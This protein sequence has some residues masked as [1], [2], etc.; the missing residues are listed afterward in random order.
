MRRIILV[1]A[2]AVAALPFLL[3]GSSAVAGAGNGVLAVDP[4]PHQRGVAHH[5]LYLKVFGQD[6]KGRPI[7]T[8]TT[9][10]G[11]TP[12]HV[13]TA[14]GFSSL[15]ATGSGQV[16]GIVDAYDAP[17]I[18]SDLQTFITTFGL[19]SMY[20]LP[21]TSA[22]SVSTGPHP[23]F[24][25]VY[26]QSK[27]RT[28]SGWALE[29]S[30]DVEWA[31]AIAPG[32]DIL[33]VEARTASLSNLLGAV[34]VAVNGGA[35]AVSMS[36]GAGDFSSEALYDSYFNKSGVTFTAA[37]GDNG[38]GTIWPS[39]SPY[40]VGVGGTT[41]NIGSGGNYVSETAWS[42]SGGGI[43]PYESEPGYQ[44]SYP[45]P[46]TGGKRGAPD[47]AYDA[48]PSTGFPVYDSTPYQGQNGWFQVGG[49][50]AG[51]PQWAALIAL[52]DEG[53]S[54]A[55]SSNNLTSSPVYNAAGSAV[56]STNY[57]DITSGTNG[58]CGSVCT[59]GSGWDFVTGLGSPQAD[60]LVPY[61]AGH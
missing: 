20:G 16:I 37:S 5:P 36:W 29:T 33:L 13:R 4:G 53:R 15:T 32:A 42:G 52:A 47:V 49:T 7:I 1:L 35:H 31:H 48:D 55:L 18:A 38:S 39:T 23:C 28:N 54:P 8:N 50:S 19:Q 58:G 57:H 6:Q 43:S 10:K 59:A 40:V 9:P 60:N 14:Y 46:S 24:Q 12:D 41:L 25:K 3:G 56:Y 21:G 26:A 44:S 61:L 11:Y 45:I 51:A 30:L 22:C 2:L 34:N 17:K 27:P